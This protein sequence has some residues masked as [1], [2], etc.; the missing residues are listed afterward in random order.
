M[1][2]VVRDVGPGGFSIETPIPFPRQSTHEFRFSGSQGGSDVVL[3]GESA[4]CLRVSGP[5][6][7]PR[8]LTGFTFVVDDEASRRGVDALVE[9]LAQRV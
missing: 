3:R 4:H 2:V 5:D 9:S 7:E 1:A 6:A 8:F